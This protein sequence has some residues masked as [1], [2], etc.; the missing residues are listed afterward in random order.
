MGQVD[1]KIY[2]KNSGK[3]ECPKAYNIL[4]VDDTGF[5]VYNTTALKHYSLSEKML[6]CYYQIVKRMHG[7]KEVKFEPEAMFNP[8][9]FI[10][11]NIFRVSCKKRKRVVYDFL[12]FNPY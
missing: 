10:N 3:L 7:N 12:H 9:F 6:I 5:I 2:A 1:F 8:P 11:G 4:L